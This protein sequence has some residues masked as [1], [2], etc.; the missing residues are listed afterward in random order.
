MACRSKTAAY[1]K[2]YDIFGE[3]VGFSVNN[4]QRTYKTLPGACIS[5]VIIMCVNLFAIKKIIDMANYKG[6]SYQEYAYDLVE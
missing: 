3:N 1:V 5:I 2:S 4:G 6:I